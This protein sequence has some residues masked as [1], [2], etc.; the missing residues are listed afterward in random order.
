MKTYTLHRIKLRSL[1]KFGIFSGLIAFF[2]PIS[3][4]VLL[5]RV[6]VVDLA[7]WMGNLTYTIPIPLPGVSGISVDSIELLHLQNFF[8]NLEKWSVLSWLYVLLLIL[9]LTA[10]VGL[11]TGVTAII[12][13]LAFNSLATLS[14][15]LQLT[16]SENMPQVK[17]DHVLSAA[18]DVPTPRR[19]QAVPHLEITSPIRRVVPITHQV[20]LIGSGPD[21]DLLLHGL[22][23]RHAQLSYEDGRYILRDFSRGDSQV[24]GH[25]VNG[26]NLIRDRFVIQLGQYSMTFRV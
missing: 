19:Q 14:G 12:T 10:A 15:G 24:Q 23:V 18:A 21:C 20:T 26:I 13:G 11:W 5:T 17:S 3:I 6:F 9:G 2:L 25:V 8:T 16:L 4:L 1:F 7:N 22:Q